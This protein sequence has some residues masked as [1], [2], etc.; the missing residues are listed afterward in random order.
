MIPVSN[1]L[2]LVDYDLL[3]ALIGPGTTQVTHYMEGCLNDRESDFHTY[4]LV[5]GNIIAILVDQ[6]RNSNAYTRLKLY[7]CGK[8]GQSKSMEIVYVTGNSSTFSSSIASDRLPKIENWAWITMGEVYFDYFERSIN[9][10]WLPANTS[11]S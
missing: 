8:F 6:V 1:A 9:T 10:L 4:G 3:R 11:V 7:E 2:Q 5:R